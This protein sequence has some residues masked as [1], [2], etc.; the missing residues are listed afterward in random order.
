LPGTRSIPFSI[1]DVF[2][3]RALAGNQLAVFT[4]AQGLPDATMQALAREMNFSE[5]TFVLPARGGG[6]ARIRI[7]TPTRE[8]PFAGHP[9]LGSAFVLAELRQLEQL[10]LETE[11]GPVPVSFSAD[12]GQAPMGWMRQPTPVISAFPG[13][14]ALL[15][16]LGIT[17][18]T[19]PVEQYDNGP[20][21]V[22]VA[23]ESVKTVAQLRPDM[24]RLAA[25]GPLCISVFAGRG[26]LWTT[27]MFAPGEGIPEDPATGA[28]AGP[29]AVHL[30]RHKR[31]PFGLQIALEQGA[32]LGRPSRLFASCTGTPERIYAVEVGGSCVTVARGAFTLPEDS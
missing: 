26:A 29:I 18:T 2:T 23:V 14:D 21:H 15:R 25:L 6:D 20:R 17:E 12:K 10:T 1:C 31:I 16:A 24:Q 5:S 28:A 9:T 8:I 7:L 4:E 19:L 13:E 30:A 3:G 27:R 22:C 11:R 32:E